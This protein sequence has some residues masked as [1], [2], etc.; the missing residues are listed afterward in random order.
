[1][2]GVANTSRIAKWGWR[3]LVGHE[4]WA[5]RRRRTG[6]RR[7][8]V[9]ADGAISR[10]RALHHRRRCG[11]LA[12]REMGRQRIF[13][14]G[15]GLSVGVSDGGHGAGPRPERRPLSPVCSPPPAVGP[16]TSRHV[17]RQQL[18]GDGGAGNESDLRAGLRPERHSVCRRRWRAVHPIVERR[19]LVDAGWWTVGRG[20]ALTSTPLGLYAGGGFTIVQPGPLLHDRG[21]ALWNGSTWLAPDIDLPSTPLVYALLTKAD[22]TLIV[23][24]DRSG[25]AVAAARTTITNP[26]TARSYPTFRISGPSVGGNGQ[27]FLLRNLT[28]G[29]SVYL[30]LSIPPATWRSC[31]FSR[32]ISFT[33][34]AL[35][36]WRAP[37]CQ[38][39][40]RLIFS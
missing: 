20:L 40:T 26:G 11:R 15:S 30:N 34:A 36:T 31:R 39:R 14:A 16:Q 2:G 12:H 23:G 22:G 21:F 6:R 3:R 25:S 38:P 19:H 35:S 9:G 13:R 8:A 7:S 17:G 10:D 32:I 33:S 37:S 5:H 29:R 27:V 4:H 18:G 24:H 1:M 28:T